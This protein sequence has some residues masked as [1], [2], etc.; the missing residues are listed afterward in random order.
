MLKPTSRAVLCGLLAASLL[1]ASCGGDDSQTE[2]DAAPDEGG[3]D[4]TST[5]SATGDG[6]L[7]ADGGGDATL[8]DS[9]SGDGGDAG[10]SGDSGNDAHDAD[11]SDGATSDAGTPS[12]PTPVGCPTGQ[13]IGDSGA[14]EGLGTLSSGLAGPWGIAIDSC[15]VYWTNWG[16]TQ[17]TSSIQKVPLAGGTTTPLAQ[18][19]TY[20]WDLAVDSKNVYWGT[21][22]YQDSGAGAIMSAPLFGGDAG[23]GTKLAVAHGPYGVA[24]NSAYVY[25][26]NYT[27]ANNQTSGEVVRVPFDGG[28]PQTLATGQQQ[29]YDIA[30]DSTRVYWSNFGIVGSSSGSVMRADL[31]G[32]N[33]APIASNQAG[34]YDIAIDANNVYWTVPGDGTVMKAPLDSDGG[35]GVPLATG[36]NV[37][38]GIAVDANY[39]YWVDENASGSVWKVPIGGGSPIPLASNQPYA[40]GIAVDAT[41]VYWTVNGTGAN[42]GKIMK[43]TPK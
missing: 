19:Q 10:D 43:L 27:T 13:A 8:G 26:V 38:Y 41:S 22:L 14:C 20:P 29:A 35:A 9:A 6:S 16:A 31:D 34:L 2:G 15:Y 21:A 28:A 37:P 30:L 42:D 23:P 5:D 7:G 12:C 33:A 11:A 18:G 32:G 40:R 3:L 25:W 36:Q 1:A 17:T 4:A 39:V 24:V